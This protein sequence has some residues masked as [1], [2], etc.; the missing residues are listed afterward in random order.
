MREKA[1]LNYVGN[2]H[3]GLP[4]V[5]FIPGAMT[6]PNVFAGLA[7][8]LP[9][10][11]AIIDWNNSDG[12]WEVETVGKK[13]LALIR[14]L[15][16]GPTVL[17]GYSWGGV[18]SLAAAIDDEEELVKGIMVADTGACAIGH[19]DPD[20]PRKLEKDWPDRELFREFSARC[21]ARPISQ[22]MY[23][24]L[25]DYAMAL[26]KDTVCQAAHSVRE[27]DFRDRLN[28]ITCPVQILHGLKDQSRSKIHAQ[29]LADGISGAELFWMD[30]GHT[31]MVELP[32]EYL[33]KLLYFLDRVGLVEDPA[34]M[35][36][37]HAETG[38]MSIIQ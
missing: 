25:E 31:P 10:Q 15:Q 5:L 36:V 13:V 14:E 34:A 35:D 2:L 22:G 18:V 7:N 29:I 21:Y 23:Q 17:A 24:Q 37:L 20:F 12:P 28:E 38:K 33:E 4:S 9:C 26:K 11:S 3:S 32:G 27:S 1:I 6:S 8:Y 19:G 30:C 16:L